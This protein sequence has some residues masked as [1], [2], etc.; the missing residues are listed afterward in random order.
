MCQNAS[1]STFCVDL[2]SARAI[3]MPAHAVDHDE[4]R[5]V[6]GDRGGDPVLVLFARPQQADI[7]VLDLQ[8]GTRALLDWA[9]F[10]SRRAQAEYFPPMIA[11]M[12]G[13]ARREAS[14]P[15]GTLVC[16]LRSVNHRFLESWLSAAR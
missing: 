13:F 3:G 10:I 12:T 14:G 11:S 1:T 4:Q 9:R 5:G 8:R 7:G 2:G 6:L 16:E 15:W